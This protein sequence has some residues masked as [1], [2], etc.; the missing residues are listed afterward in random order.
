M[1]VLVLLPDS[2]FDP[3]EASIPWKIL[4]ES[5]CEV[6]FATPAGKQAAADPVMTGGQ[7]LGLWKPFLR[8]DPRGRAAYGELEQ[9]PEFRKPLAW[10]KLGAPDR[11]DALMLPGGH[12]AEGM[13]EYLESG[14][15]QNFVAEFY[16]LGR[17]LAAI[18][19]GVVLAARSRRPDGKSILFG[20]KVTA[21]PA[22][23]ELSAWWM[24]RLWLGSYYR[25]YLDRTVESEVR[26]V[27]TRPG[28]DFQ[29]G[30]RNQTRDRPDRP[31][32]GFIVR[33]GNL[34]TGRWPGDAHR[35]GLELSAMVRMSRE[36]AAPS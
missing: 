3:T 6:V 5:G 29:V 30:P 7:G 22:W 19:H 14:T 1:P 28:E 17:P 27:L 10:A 25:T 20:K 33:D 8:A 35:F 9:A 13:R 31:E 11:Y 16:K 2:G 36:S 24:T 4:K 21:L 34:L 23:M 26:S 12:R 15:L 18:C 32:L